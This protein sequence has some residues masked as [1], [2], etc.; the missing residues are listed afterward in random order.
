MNTQQAAREVIKDWIRDLVVDFARTDALMD[1]TRTRDDLEGYFR[2]T[3]E[4]KKR[5][6]QRIALHMASLHRPIESFWHLLPTSSTDEGEIANK[7]LD[8]FYEA[9]QDLENLQKI[10]EEALGG[11]GGDETAHIRAAQA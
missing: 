4:P 6:I 9:K 7:Y 1:F 8:S 3:P 2:A 5:L 11:Q 10:L